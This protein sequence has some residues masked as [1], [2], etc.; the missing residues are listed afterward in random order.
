M[1]NYEQKSFFIIKISLPREWH[2]TYENLRYNS[3]SLPLFSTN[4]QTAVSLK[5]QIFTMNQNFVFC[6]SK[7][8]T[9]SKI[10][11]LNSAKHASTTYFLFRKQILGEKVWSFRHLTF[12]I[13]TNVATSRFMHM[14]EWI[15]FIITHWIHVVLFT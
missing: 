6:Y 14:R 7:M 15:V 1:K 12:N 3:F 9:S 5:L 4:N 10:N 13:L 11:G 8:L 2:D